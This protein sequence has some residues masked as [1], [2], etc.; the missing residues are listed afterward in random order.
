[1]RKLKL[2]VQTSID[3][4][5]AETNGRTD[6]MLWNWG[7]EWTWDNQLQKDFT[8]LTNSIDCILLSRQMA[9]EGFVAHWENMS[10]QNNNT[11]SAFAKKISETRKI[12]FSKTIHQSKWNNTYIAKGNFVDEINTLKKQKGMD[13]IVYG[14]ATFVSSLITAGLIDEYYLFVNPTALGSGMSIFMGRTDLK[15]VKTTP[16]KCGIAVIIYKHDLR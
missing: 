1:M 10:L 8:D 5:I 6:W 3:G 4:Y 9:E 7:D 12:V 14:G 15:L 16:Y 2:L 13:I 11:Q